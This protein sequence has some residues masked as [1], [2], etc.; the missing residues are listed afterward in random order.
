MQ[1]EWQGSGLGRLEKCADKVTI[2]VNDAAGKTVYTEHSPTSRLA[3]CSS[4]GMARTGMEASW[5]MAATAFSVNAAQG[6]TAVEATPLADSTIQAMSWNNGTP[7]LHLANGK[8][9]SMD[10]I[11]QLDLTCISIRRN[12]LKQYQFGT[13]HLK[14]RRVIMGFQQ[15]LSGV[16]AAAKQLDVI[17]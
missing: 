17:W 3:R 12:R 7:V 4:S 2:N 6:D 14:I 1:G 5:P 16:G 9:T 11:R 8:E 13:R 10:A 15:G